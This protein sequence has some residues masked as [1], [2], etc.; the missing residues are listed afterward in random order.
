MAQAKIAFRLIQDEDGYPPET[1]E[2]LWAN[3][4]AGEGLFTIDNIPFFARSV[5]FG[6]QVRAELVDGQWEF[7]E[8]VHR[9]F[10]STV[11]ILVWNKDETQSV[12]DEFR[13]LGCASELSGLPGLIAVDVPPELS[14]PNIFSILKAGAEGG[15]WDYEE[16]CIGED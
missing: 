14:Y 6:D 12:R 13:A 2:T 1:V 16:A 15:R 4:G 11:R 8:V 9:S 10:H 5:A 7:R 3:S